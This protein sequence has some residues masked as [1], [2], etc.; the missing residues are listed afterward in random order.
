MKRPKLTYSLITIAVLLVVFL[1]VISRKPDSF[2]SER[3]ATINAPALTIFE[4]V[5]DLHKWNAWSPYVAYDPNAK[6]TYS[7]PQSGVGAAMSWD[8]NSKAGA[9]TMTIVESKPGELIRIQLD[10][11]KPFK[12]TDMSTFTFRPDGGQTVTT[13]SMDGPSP[14]ISKLMG[15]F[16]NLD[17]MIGDDFTV[18]LAK[19]RTLTE[20]GK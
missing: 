20:S 7:G 12:T 15:T 16:F 13:W 5:N 8:G 11:T 1:I 18:G 3:T 2:H 17:K 6:Q 14:F 4:Q 19:L 10:F 9:G